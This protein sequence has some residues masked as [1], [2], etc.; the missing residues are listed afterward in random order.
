MYSAEENFGIGSELDRKQL[1]VSVPVP[2]GF[3]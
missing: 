1:S 2:V 3:W